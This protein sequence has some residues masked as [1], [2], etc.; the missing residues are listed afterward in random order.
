MYVCLCK[1]ITDGKVRQL[2]QAGLDTPAA[3]I[4]ALALDDDECCGFC[5]HHI[6]R[7]VAIAR[8]GDPLKYGRFVLDPET[9]FEH[10]N[11]DNAP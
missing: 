11:P 8:G 9:R 4:Q 3:L 2:G 1:G 7:M 5:M 6:G 10:D